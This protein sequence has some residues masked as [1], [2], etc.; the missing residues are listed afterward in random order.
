MFYRILGLQNTANTFLQAA[1]SVVQ[2]RSAELNQCGHKANFCRKKF[3]TILLLVLRVGIN[4]VISTPIC[5]TRMP[6]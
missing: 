6:M 3:R 4:V 5:L 1:V 2:S